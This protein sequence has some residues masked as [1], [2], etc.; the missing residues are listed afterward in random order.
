[1]VA[2]LVGSGAEAVWLT[3]RVDACFNLATG[4]HPADADAVLQAFPAVFALRV[5]SPSWHGIHSDV[6]G[7]EAVA[8]RRGVTLEVDRRWLSDP[9]PSGSCRH[10]AQA[11]WQ[12]RALLARI[13]GIHVISD[14]DLGLPVGRVD[15]SR[16][17]LDVRGRGL[18][19]RTAARVLAEQH[20]IAVESYD[21]RRISVS[22]APPEEL[23]V[24]RL[25]L[26][27]AA[28]GAWSGAARPQR[29]DPLA[30]L[31]NPGEQVMSPGEV[32]R[33]RV[34]AV[35]LTHAIGRVCAE[36]VIA[37]PPGFAVLAPG[38][39][40]TASAVGWLLEALACSV[41]VR[42]AADPTLGTLRVVSDL[43]VPSSARG[44]AGATPSRPC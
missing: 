11:T 41:P 17:L 7:L 26:A 28:L 12:A 13:P 29:P 14:A 40:V 4:V 16:V 3:P 32:A 27:V 44:I 34:H 10:R 33:A 38:E 31:P 2:D 15:R 6:A 20:G 21:A 43:V 8:A 23:T 35:P 9:G 39:L 5:V 19:G 30:A 1:M 18:D 25:V 37:D 24:R 36:P 42:D 22:V